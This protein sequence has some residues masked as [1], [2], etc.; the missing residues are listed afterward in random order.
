MKRFWKD[1]RGSSLVLVMVT[2]SFLI[3]LAGAV[4]MT[5]I[6]N[7][8][9]KASQKA[10]QENFYQT[11][12]ILDA[13]AAG[14]Q[15]ESSEASAKA[16]E[17]AL[18]EYN[19]SMTAAGDSVD[20][21]Y[22]KDFL[23]RML[24]RLT[25]GVSYDPAV[26]SYKYLDSVLEEYLKDNQVI[27]YV[28]HSDENGD[29]K[30]VLDMDG[31]AII[32]REVTVKK[33]HDTQKSYE[34]KLTTDIRIE[35]PSVV[36]EAHSEY[37]DYALLAD[38]QIV[39]DNGNI[40]PQIVG[41]MYSGTVNR[42]GNEDTKAGIVISG[43][44]SL[45]INAAQIITR[46]D[47]TVSNSSELNIRKDSVA[48]FAELWA[49]NILTSGKGTGNTLDI[50]AHA[51]IA[52]DLEIN[53]AHDDV[54]LKG[55]YYGYNFV[56]DYSALPTP[57][58]SGHIKLSKT[59][60]YSSS[61]LV[62]GYD[63]RLSMQG[64]DQ[65][66]LAG[67]TFISKKT[68]TGEVIPEVDSAGNS[69]PNPDIELGES[70]AVKSNQLSYFVSALKTGSTDGFVKRVDDMKLEDVHLPAAM[71]GFGT[72]DSDSK[73]G[74]DC[75]YFVINDVTYLFDYLSYE[76]RLGI[77]KD[78]SGNKQFDVAKMIND[79]NIDKTQPLKLYARDDKSV[80]QDPVRYFYLN[81]ADSKASQSFYNL[82]YNQSTQQTIYD[83]VNK[84]YVDAIGIQLPSG[85]GSNQILLA[86]GNLM[87][88]DQGDLDADG[89]AKLKVRI[90]NANT[91]PT[92]HF[93]QYAMNKSRFYMSKQLAL[94]DDYA[95]VRNSN[96]WR[97]YDDA[98]TNR[99]NDK[100]NKSGK[101]D[102]TNLFDTLVDRS[103]LT[104]T[105]VGCYQITLDDGTVTNCGYIV[106][107][108]DVEWPNDYTGKGYSQNDPCFILTTGNVDVKGN[109]YKGLILSGDNVELST[110]VKV[111][112]YGE[113]IEK[114]FA[115]DKS[116]ASPKFYDIMSKYFRKSV[117]ATIGTDENDNDVNNVT[118]ENWKKNN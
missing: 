51:F 42:T 81:F 37:L 47:V 59:A 55:W 19:L 5:T 112:A 94:V 87:Y 70:L 95:D 79:G 49:E 115:A 67:R 3:L 106:S 24:E 111:S 8:R 74:V 84:T 50:D 99:P 107:D 82:F 22:T 102:K 57:D 105:K 69:L 110:S 114:L 46:G 61:I 56:D 109:S 78:A 27:Y 6:T 43:G 77:P 117:D 62:N 86:S 89:K 98:D 4:I 68:N 100:M 12:T 23:N 21:N 16:Y 45:K 38:D 103:K 83:T 52:D 29:P 73:D 26:T 71:P 66:V 116:D 60:S 54:T 97:L 88:S 76:N 28:E 40:S 13:I 90:D 39:A 25:G 53:G 34:T 44:A 108:G 30:G 2:M 1:R 35:V 15:N 41:N 11:D 10:S 93:S 17:K 32:L 80:S 9:L 36:T 65:L 14:I 75:Y 20:D 96:V 85:S 63:S 64:L 48:S 104:E 72:F 101:S 92:A 33:Q 113:A 18:G 118:Y 31:D 58:A 91:D 7:I